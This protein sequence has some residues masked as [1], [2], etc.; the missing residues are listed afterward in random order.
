M[1]VSQLYNVSYQTAIPQSTYLRTCSLYESYNAHSPWYLVTSASA[2]APS[3][4]SSL[5]LGI[6]TPLLELSKAACV[7][8][9]SAPV[10]QYLESQ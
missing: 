6:V 9:V 5:Y 1:Y 10:C 3:L 7:H 8:L 4:T 2:K